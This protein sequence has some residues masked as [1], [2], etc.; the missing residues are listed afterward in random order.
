MDLATELIE[1][2]VRDFPA[3]QPG[4]RPVHAYG[5]VAQGR[6]RPNDIA[7]RHS[8]AALFA[9]QGGVDVTARFSNGTG[10]RGVPDGRRD[11]RGMA[12]RFHGEPGKAW[13]MVC[14]TL[15]V[16]FV[17]TVAEFRQLTEAAVPPVPAKSRPWWRGVL[18]SLNLRTPPVDPDPGDA[19]V[20]ALSAHLPGACPALVAGF[21]AGIPESFATLRYHPVHAFELTGGDG[22]RCW[23]RFTWDPVAGVRNVAPGAGLSLGAELRTRCEKG[24]L[25][26]VL[27]A[28]V[29]DQG[30][31]VSDP[32]RPWPETRRRLVLGHL[33]LDRFGADPA[34]A[35][36]T[37]TGEELAFNPHVLPDGIRACPDDEIFQV[38]GDAYRTSAAIRSRARAASWS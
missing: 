36:A 5:F 7:A 2:I 34:E 6:F 32:S 21:N 29:A 16:F 20:V 1:G 35:S 27:R 23:V 33:T 17:R 15:P 31:D 37:D 13:D 10:N 24:P 4:T 22:G 3:H 12:V 25:Q 19:G 14:M 11:V 26:F 8:S 38:R 28:Q 9:D 18:D 30:D